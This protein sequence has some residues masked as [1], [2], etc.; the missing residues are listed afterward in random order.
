MNDIINEFNDYAKEN[1]IDIY[2]NEIYLSKKNT[3][4]NML[5]LSSSLESLL[6]KGSTK[7]DL[8]MISPIYLYRF[9]NSVEDLKKYISKDIL[10]LYSNKNVKSIGTKNNKIMGL[11]L[12]ND[13]GVLYSNNIYLKKYNLTVP[14][15]WD[16]LIEKAKFIMDREKEQGNSDLIGFMGNFQNSEILVPSTMEYLYSFRDTIDSPLP[17]FNSENAHRAFKKLL[18]IK[19]KVSS[20]DSFRLSEDKIVPLLISRK[21]IFGRFWNV[22]LS[23][24]YTISRLPGEKKGISASWINGYYLLMNK[25]ITEE[26][27]EAVARVIEFTLSK[28]IQKMILLK[29]MKI[30]GSDVLFQDEDLCKQFDCDFYH[31]LQ[32]LSR[33]AETASEQ[34][35]YNSKFINYVYNYI[36]NGADLDE[37]LQNLEYMAFTYSIEYGSIYGI[38]SIVLTLFLFVL[39]MGSFS[40]MLMKKFNY[41]LGVFDKDFW[42]VCL[43]GLSSSLMSNFCLVGDITEFKCNIRM[44]I[45][46]ISISLYLYTFFIKLLICFPK[47]NKYSEFFNNHCHLVLLTLFITDIMCI[48]PFLVLSPYK[49]YHERTKV[50]DKDINIINSRKISTNTKVSKHDSDKLNFRERMLSYHYANSSLEIYGSSD[51][52]MNKFSGSNDKMNKI[53]GSNDKM[54][55]INRSNSSSIPKEPQVVLYTSIISSDQKTDISND[56]TLM[57]NKINNSLNNI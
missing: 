52:K 23:G 13:V 49:I 15:T 33:E 5:N 51:D 19:E 31:S 7:Y 22:P 14:E 41:F 37:T 6:L 50:D 9:E 57:E 26:K 35:D 47:R 20:N 44:V 48:I 28:N 3:T 39:I 36:Y 17:N 53:S 46:Y 34:T 24:L 16:E 25:Y 56:N 2:L 43:L 42:F 1:N 21:V 38:I 30:S 54:N 10:D 40:L 55:K 8:I 27:K 45:L 18:E 12:Y 29:Y 32:F 11:P 4:I